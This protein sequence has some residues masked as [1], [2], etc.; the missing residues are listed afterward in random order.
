MGLLKKLKIQMHRGDTAYRSF[1]VY[2]HDG[3][4]FDGQFDEIYL[5]VKPNAFT[6]NAIFQKRLST[7]EIEKRGDEYHFVILPEDTNGLNYTDYY[8]DVQLDIDEPLFKQTVLGILRID[9]E[10]TFA[11]NEGKG[12]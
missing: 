8:F 5:T 3:S 11:V 9:K 12:L 10:I 2:N 7:G 4:V 6:R 1:I